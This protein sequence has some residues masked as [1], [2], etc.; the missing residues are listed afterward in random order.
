[1]KIFQIQDKSPYFRV[2]E[3]GH[4]YY[5]T[6]V[7]LFLDSH[8]QKMRP[9]GIPWLS[10]HQDFMLSL[11]RAKVWSL[12]GELRSHK[13]HGMAVFFFFFFFN[14]LLFRLP[15][16]CWLKLKNFLAVAVRGDSVR[17]KGLVWKTK[18][19]HRKHLIKEVCHIAIEG[20]EMLETQG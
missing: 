17:R 16:G 19:F 2:V 14:S 1:M 6:V 3:H 4:F 8:N 13:P 20:L 18:Y 9:L 7:S 12:V 11:L 10:S 15:G 5:A